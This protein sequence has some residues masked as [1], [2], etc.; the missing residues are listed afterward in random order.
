M[1]ASCNG[2]VA[3]YNQAG[4]ARDDSY[5]RSQRKKVQS[6]HAANPSVVRKSLASTQ[7]NRTM[8]R[9]LASIGLCCFFLAA[10]AWAADDKPAE[11]KAADKKF[12]Y[13]DLQPKT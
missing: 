8:R 7:E 2:G 1:K 4:A 6:R 13:I 11:K 5:C 3:S 9:L 12:S 10:L